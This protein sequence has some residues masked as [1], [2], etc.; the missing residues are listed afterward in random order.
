MEEYVKGAEPDRWHWRKDCNQYP[1]VIIRKRF[2]RPTSDLCDNCLDIEAR[3][4]R[5]IAA[6]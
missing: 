4:L 2:N 3:A 5:K 6:T 1:T